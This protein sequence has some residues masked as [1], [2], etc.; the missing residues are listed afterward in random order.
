MFIL[1]CFADEISPDLDVQIETLKRNN[2]HYIEFRG[3]WGKNVLD[4]TDYELDTVKAKLDE[5]NLRIS[6][7][8]SP[9]GKVDIRDNFEG[10]PRQI[11]KSN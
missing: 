11:Q 5:N 6:S 2:M 9:V 3:V 7:I 1:S 10:H 8:G 4:L